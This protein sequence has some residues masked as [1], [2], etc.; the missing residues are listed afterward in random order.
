[1]GAGRGLT[2]AERR[3]ICGGPEKCLSGEHILKG[4]AHRITGGFWEKALGGSHPHS[5]TE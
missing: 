2:L 3:K 4:C 5:G 1:M